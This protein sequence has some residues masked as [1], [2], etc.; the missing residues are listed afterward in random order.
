MP[1]S[2]MST[3]M[4]PLMAAPCDRGSPASRGHRPAAPA[5]RR[6]G[7][8]RR[9]STRQASDTTR[10]RMIH[11]VDGG[12]QRGARGDVAPTDTGVLGPDGGRRGQRQTRHRLVQGVHARAALKKV[13][14]GP[15][16][17]R[18]QR[19]D[20]VGVEQAIDKVAGKRRHRL[21]RRWI[22]RCG[23]SSRPA[24]GSTGGS[25]H[26]TSLGDRPPPRRRCGC[27]PR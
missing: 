27:A 22:R 12:G 20:P 4:Q 6:S 25:W 18:S 19:P 3:S 21:A 11:G 1:R 14:A 24:A 7:S 16:L 8:R 9:A 5:R 2:P 17:R 10:Q 26:G 13:S 23:T 15:V